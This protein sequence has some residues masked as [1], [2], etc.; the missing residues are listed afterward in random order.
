MD[1]KL[2][3]I[4]ALPL[5]ANPDGRADVCLVTARGSRRWIIPKGNPI[6]GL[7][8]HEVA[9]QEAV[10]EAGLVGVAKRRCI[11]TFEFERIRDGREESCTVDVYVLMVK[12]RLRKWDEMDQRS[13]LRCDVRTAL[14]L[15][16]SRGLANLISQV[17]PSEM[18]VK[19][20]P[21]KSYWTSFTGSL[22]MLAG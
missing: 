4:A 12:R 20:I 15:I 7:A 3:Q 17:V 21:A 16:R 5:F 8:P 1:R 2:H 19:R 6:R 22:A 11:G 18:P 13:V 14:S 9:T 10:E